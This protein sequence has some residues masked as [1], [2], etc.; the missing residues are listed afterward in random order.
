MV[1]Q[2]LDPAEWS[3]PFRSSAEFVGL[4]GEGRLGVEPAA[5]RQAYLDV[6]NDHLHQIQQVTRKLH[7]DHLLL[8]SQQPMGA[9]LSHFLARRAAT[10]RKPR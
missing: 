7:F 1:L 10:T 2:I 5:L 8:D 4:E 9:P 6:L 3:F